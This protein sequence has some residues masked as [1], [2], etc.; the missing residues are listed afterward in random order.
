MGCMP[1]VGGVGVM[2]IDGIDIVMGWLCKVNRGS[3]VLIVK[4]KG[5]E[6]SECV[7]RW[8]DEAMDWG[9]WKG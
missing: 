5:I 8:S 3:R 1:V 4:G 9:G 2:S 6:K 7:G